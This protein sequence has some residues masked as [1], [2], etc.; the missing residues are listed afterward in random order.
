MSDS[1]LIASKLFPLSNKKKSFAA[2]CVIPH[3]VD[4][5]IVAKILNQVVLR[6]MKEIKVL[7]IA[8]T[9]TNFIK[10]VE[11]FAREIVSCRRVLSSSLHGLIASHA[12]GIPGK[13]FRSFMSL[14]LFKTPQYK[15][16]CFPV[17]F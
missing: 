10:F 9:E 8:S 1:G 4:K 2:V 5:T 17:F 3:Y 13:D 12:Y 7:S 16:M 14:K 11:H 15:N 6:N